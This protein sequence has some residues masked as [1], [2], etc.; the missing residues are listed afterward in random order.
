[1]VNTPLP[2]DIIERFG[3]L[4][5]LKK[6]TGNEWSSACPQCGGAR[7]GSDPSDRFRFWE[8][9]GAACNF[10]CRRCGFSGF[11]DDNKPGRQMTEAEILEL[12][13]IRKRQAEQEAARLAAKID[14]LQRAAYWKGWHDAMTEQQRQLWRDAGIPDELQ[15]Y[16]QLGYMPSYTGK[17]FQ[18]PALTIPYFSNGW[19]ATTIQ[20]RLLQPP[21]PSDKYRFQAG[22]RADI[23]RAEPDNDIENAICLC[24]GMK[25]AAVTFHQVVAR[26]G[27]R[28]GVVAVPS[29]MPGAD[30]LEQ[31]KNADPLYVIL[32]PDA[33]RP[34]KTPDGRRLPPAVNRLVKLLDVPARLVKL[35]CKADDFFT[36]Y[37]GTA[38]DFM[39]YLR[40]GKPV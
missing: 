10:W 22:F 31:L 3:H 20:Y 9:P 29:K 24:E 13:E 32:D 30:M 6:R 12:E 37:G 5:D 4:P 25:K 23:W 33:Y 35:P 18:S 19:Q 40:I 38:Y 39:S 2:P 15:K 34:T 36:M 11:T 17:D 16:W 26:A 1:M 27:E 28:L 8:R 7:G 21:E 14:E